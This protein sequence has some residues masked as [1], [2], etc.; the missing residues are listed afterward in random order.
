MHNKGTEVKDLSHRKQKQERRIQK[1]ER[2]PI[3][4]GVWM[5][6]KIERYLRGLIIKNQGLELQ[7]RSP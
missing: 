6:G 4:L 7:V 1:Q 3:E 5:K 2:K